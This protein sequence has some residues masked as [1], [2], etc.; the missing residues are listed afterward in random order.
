MSIL[1]ESTNGGEIV[2]ADQHE[3]WPPNFANLDP[4]KELRL[5]RA[6]IAQLEHQQTMSSS[7]SSSAGFDLV[8]QNENEIGN[9]D[10]TLGDRNEIEQEKNH[11]GKEARI[12]EFARCR[13]KITKIELE[14]KEVNE[15]LKNTKELLGKNHEQMEGW[16][17]DQKTSKMEQYQKQKM[18]EYQKQKMEEYQKQKMEED[19]VNTKDRSAKTHEQM[20]EWKRITK[21]E[22]ENKTLRAELEHQKLL[23]AHNALQTKLE[24]YQ[25]K[26]TI[27]ML[28]EKLKVSIDQFSLMQSGQKALLERLNGLSEQQKVD[29]KGL[30]AT[31]DQRCNKSGEQ[32]NNILEQFIEGQ[33][34]KFEEQKETDRMRQKQMDELG[35]SSKKELE[36]AM[37][38]LKGELI[39]KME[40]Y[41]NKQQQ[42]NIDALTEAGN[43]EGN[44]CLNA[45]NWGGTPTSMLRL[46]GV[47]VFEMNQLKD[48]LI[49][50]MEQYQKEQQ[51]NIDVLT[52]HKRET[53][54]DCYFTS[55]GVGTPTLDFE[56]AK[57]VEHFS[58][59][60]AK[61]NELERKQKAD[62]KEHRAKIDEEYQNKQQL[63]IED[64]QKTVVEFNLTPQ[65]RWDSAACHEKLTLIKPNGLIAQYTGKV[66]LIRSVF[67][68]WPI[69]NNALGIFYYEVKILAKKS[70][71]S[72]GLV[73]KQMPLDVWVGRYDGTYGYQSDGFFMGHEVKGCA[74]IGGRPYIERKP[75]FGGGDVVGCGVNLA[76]RQ[77]IYTKNGQ[78][79]ETTGLFVH[80]AADLF[81]CV[82]LLRS[83]AKIEANF[84]PNFEFKF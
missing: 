4:S 3:C 82:S 71:I 57:I 58:L 22:Q 15:E 29:Q 73:T 21:L 11:G 23:I 34:K 84:G 32:L 1:T 6:R 54:G 77:I 38:Q 52:E 42:K 26:Q 14:L 51:Q 44:C 2:T 17:I 83:G 43:G 39:A 75:I 19:L 66:K 40:E 67:A 37:N 28:T 74:H 20:E 25:N 76:T 63:N 9:A 61:I 68:E 59:Q 30:S 45:F 60:Q 50:K 69:P 65:N 10:D 27:D 47:G 13:E 31:I 53:V 79:L 5:L 49:A 62:Q 80:S 81:P 78:R 70:A 48:E 55:I 56:V 35:N 16:K 33:N 24:E 36:K 64:L 18:E 12:A 41:Q 72:F 8:A 7:T 46:V